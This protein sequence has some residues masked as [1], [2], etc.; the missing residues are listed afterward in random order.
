MISHA[1]RKQ[2]NQDR[3][4]F[5]DDDLN[6]G[7]TGASR[8]RKKLP[9]IDDIA[10]SIGMNSNTSSSAAVSS[11]SSTS[12][13]SDWS[14]LLD[15]YEQLIDSYIRL[16]KKAQAGDITAVTEYPTVMQ[17]ALSVQQKLEEGQAN[18]DLS[19]DDIQK[20]LKLQQKMMSAAMN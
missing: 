19:A 8:I 12:S 13:S 17:K 14:A 2:E 18:G 5:N 7:F 15:D 16:M 4:S 10:N 20:L 1:G 9:S 11:T 6:S 3:L